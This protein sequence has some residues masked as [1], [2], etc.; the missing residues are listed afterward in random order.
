M[1]FPRLSSPAAG[2]MVA[3]FA[4]V[5]LL[6]GSSY[7]AIHFALETLPPLLAAGMRF[8]TAGSLLYLLVRRGGARP[9]TRLHWRSTFITGTIMF[10]VANG[11]LMLGQ[12]SI[13]SGVAATVNALVPLWF[14]LLGWLWL[15]EDRLSPRVI[16]GLVTG[17]GGVALLV[18]PGESAGT[19]DATGV[20]FVVF[21]TL[22]WTFGSLLSRKLPLPD[23]PL[24]TAAMNLLTGG[25]MLLLVSLLT[26][27]IA[28]LDVA[29]ISARSV[30]AVLYLALGPSLTGFSS[31]MWLLA[32]A[33]AN[34]VATYGYVNPMIA[35]FLGW[36]LAGE[37]L[38]PET[39]LAS[40][41]IIASVVL[42][43]TAR[44]PKAA[45]AP[46][47]TIRARLRALAQRT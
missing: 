25:I 39:L 37:T 31:Y 33:P 29:A 15:A 28:R 3:S 19:I 8:I 16:I 5:Y 34:R 21:S 46:P 10:C 30:L 27:E 4:A 6:W 41:V 43:T 36:L 1:S 35:V 23:S 11:S 22:S 14:A 42:I 45:A 9:P 38:T 32:N 12:R 24:L 26:G 18:G 44:K 20:L 47:L 7:L 17:F 40:I 2:R 13:P